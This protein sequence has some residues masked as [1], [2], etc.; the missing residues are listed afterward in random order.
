MSNTA[1]DDLLPH[2]VESYLVGFRSPVIRAV[3]EAVTQ[4][5]AADARASTHSKAENGFLLA[6]Q[7]TEIARQIEQIGTA[8]RE[9]S[10]QT[11]AIVLARTSD[12]ICK[13][14]R[15]SSTP[16][17]PDEFPPVG[18]AVG[19]CVVV[20]G[21]LE[22]PSPALQAGVLP[23]GRQNHGCLART[24]TTPLQPSRSQE[25]GGSGPC[26]NESSLHRQP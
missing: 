21:R 22:R 12:G 17:G 19:L 24:Q 9:K 6:K 20:P 1:A 2:S 10:A 8:V 4:Q 23:I 11:S 15:P 3:V 5:L 16:R 13:P 25:N 18:M 14:S 7:I 26:T